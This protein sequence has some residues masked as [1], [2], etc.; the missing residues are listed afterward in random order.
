MFPVLTKLSK[1]VFEFTYF[2]TWF[3]SFETGTS[4]ATN[5][6]TLLTFI[7]NY[8]NSCLLS[9]I[10]MKLRNGDIKSPSVC[11]SVH[12]TRGISNLEPSSR[13]ETSRAISSINSSSTEMHVI[14][15]YKESKVPIIENGLHSLVQPFLLN[16]L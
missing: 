10:S 6:Y 4:R 16:C 5:E 13:Q 9:P 3:T 2:L 14:L 7:L 8:Q 1:G 15:V 12:M 11:L